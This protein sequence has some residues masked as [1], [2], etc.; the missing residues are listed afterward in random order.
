MY[1]CAKQYDGMEIVEQKNITIPKGE[2]LTLNGNILEWGGKEICYVTS[3]VAFSH[4]A[5]NDDDKG[6]ERHAKTHEILSIIE[7][8]NKRYGEAVTAILS[9]IDQENDD[10]LRQ[11]QAQIEEIP[12][13]PR[14]FFDRL[15]QTPSWA[16][17]VTYDEWGNGVWNRNFYEAPLEVLDEMIAFFA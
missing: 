15:K 17:C 1:I 2:T 11:A 7:A 9:Q 16:K 3:F 5:K 14:D 12:Y 4:F 6:L 8:E 10:E 13:K